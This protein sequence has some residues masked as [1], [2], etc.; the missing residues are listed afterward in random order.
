MRDPY[1]CP[2]CD[3]HSTRRWNLDVH[4]KRRH[5]VYLRGRSDRY[6]ANNPP[7]YSNSVQFGHAT[8]ADSAGDTSQPRYIPQQGPLRTSQNFVNPLYRPAPTMEDQRHGTGLSQDTIVKIE[9]LKELVYKYPQ[10]CP[11]ADEIITWVVYC[12]A[13]G[14]NRI[15]DQKLE[16]LRRIDSVV[17]V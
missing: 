10:Y 3:Q 7:L 1:H 2:H 14:D 8:I 15:L 5:G 13:N 11:N 4:I 6:M 9:E 16:Q 17:K 12:S